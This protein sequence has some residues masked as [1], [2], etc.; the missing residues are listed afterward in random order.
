MSDNGYYVNFEF[1]LV[2]ESSPMTWY[3]DYHILLDDLDQGDC[4]FLITKNT[5]LLS[6]LPRGQ[7]VK[8]STKLT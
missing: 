8:R 3:R 7:S 2:S 5:L 6:S 1:C 4:S